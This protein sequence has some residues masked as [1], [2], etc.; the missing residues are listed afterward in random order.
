MTVS[1]T[2]GV[3]ASEQIQV[4]SFT[5]STAGSIAV[6]G[7]LSA[8]AGTPYNVSLINSPATAAVSASPY[9]VTV[10]PIVNSTTFN[11]VTPSTTGALGTVTYEGSNFYAAWI[12]DGSNNF[13]FRIR[14]GNQGAAVGK[15]NVTLLNPTGTVANLGPIQLAPSIAANGEVTLTSAA[16]KAA[17]GAFGRSD[18]LITVE[19]PV[20]ELSVKARVINGSTGVVTEQSLGNGLYNQGAEEGP[21]N[22]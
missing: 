21:L 4:G 20:S 9:S 7:T 6:P 1:F 13:D 2:G 15:V 19:G 5:P 11:P 12:G 8:V 17:F 18:M 3:G 22:N 16:L 10:T 14:I